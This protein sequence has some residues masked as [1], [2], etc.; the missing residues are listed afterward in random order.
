L[1]GFP[2]TFGPVSLILALQNGPG[3]AAQA[4]IGTLAGQIAVCIFCLAYSLIAP[5]TNWIASVTLAIFAFGGAALICNSFTLSL[6]LTFIAAILMT[7]LLICFTPSGRVAHLA[8]SL[9]AWDIPALSRVGI[10][11]NNEEPL[12]VR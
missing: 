1:I 11:G 4:A 5:K 3:F 8:A 7:C 10:Q 12:N 6:L 9:P 2:L